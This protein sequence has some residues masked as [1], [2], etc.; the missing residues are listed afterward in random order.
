MKGIFTKKKAWIPYTRAWLLK[1]GAL[2]LVLFGLSLSQVL[3]QVVVNG[4]VTDNTTAEGLPGAAVLIK[5][6]STGT[7][8]DMDGNFRIEVPGPTTVLVVS[9]IGYVREEIVVG[10]RTT[11]NVALAPD[12][13]QLDELVVV[14]YGTQRKSD[15]TGAV[16][17]IDAAEMK[18]VAA[19]D[20]SQMLQGRT[21]GV[22]VNTD[23]HPGAMPRVRIRGI[24][25]FGDQEP[26]YVIDGVL[27]DNPP[28]DLNP[29][30]I[31]SMQVLKDASAAAIYGSRGANGVI[32][33]TTR[34]GR[35]NSPLKVEYNGYY[36]VDHVWQRI[37]VTNREQYQ[38]LQNETQRAGGQTLAPAND[39]NSPNFIDDIDTDWQREGLKT[40]NRQNHNVVLSGGGEATTYNISLDFFG[41][42]GTFIGN[43][44]SYD[45]YSARIN[46]VSEKGIFKTGISLYYAHSFE[47]SLTFR[48]DILLGGRPPLITDLVT[49]IPTMPVYDPNRLG[50][51][52]GTSST[53]ERGIVL[54]AIGANSLIENTV[55]VDR[56]IGSGWGE[57]ALLDKGGH[58]VRYKLNLA[59]DRTVAQDNAFVPAFDLGYFFTNDIARMNVGIRNWSMSLVE[60]TLHYDK[61]FNDKHALSAL[62]GATYQEGGFGVLGS[63][64]QGFSTP[65]IRNI[66]LGA[67][68]TTSQFI[69]E[70]ALASVLGRINYSFDDRYLLTASF[71]RD[72]SSRFA[73]QLR[74]GDYPSVALGW[75]L[76]NETFFALPAF[77]T[78]FK[79]RAS[80]GQLGNQTIPNY[81][82]IPTIN[83]TMPYNFG[84]VRVV[85]G[86]QAQLNAENIRWET[87]IMSNAGFDAAFFENRITLTAE[88]YRSTTEDILVGVPIPLTTGANNT[89]IVNAG[90]LRNSGVEFELGYH[91]YQGEFTFDIS[92]NAYTLKNR[93]LALG[94]DEP[95]YG[96]GARTEVGREIG[97]HFG[98]D[99]IGIFQSDEEVQAH[100][101][102]QQ[103]TAPGDV[104]FR[105]VNGDGI[106]NEQDRVYLG[107]GLP[108]I[109]Y[110]FNFAARYKGFDFTLFASGMGDYLINSR[111]YRDL[112]HTQDYL[113]YHE[114]ALG[115]WTPDNPSSTQ[116]RLVAGDPN[117]N[118][119]DSNREGWLQ[120]G[121]H[122][123][124]NTIS[125]GY[126]LPDGLIKGMSM[127]R[128]YTTAQNPYTF[129]AYKAYNPD[130]TSGTFNP[131]FDFGSFPRPRTILFGVQVAF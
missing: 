115:R 20:M 63:A 23:G 13:E 78:E 43:G 105:D 4:R 66:N 32:I 85:G 8:T 83:P 112:M 74:Y 90:S 65:Y 5:G 28:R 81:A 114:D 16:A 3:A 109:Y 95:I 60:N 67:N 97:Q 53:I 121:T 41:N 36:G 98:Y 25:T 2:S 82:Y 68:R 75:K 88:Y 51:F 11:I 94:S 9:Y 27:L 84:G 96:V 33:I 30:D 44:P 61:T 18:K 93:V 14:G 87:K 34:Q 46:T 6:T 107:S 124:I 1:A 108:G 103:G 102:Q 79:L 38:M 54:N 48:D 17:V 130:F 106:I 64:A 39:P 37:P 52:G 62:V 47:N 129:Q 29:N 110:G 56:I 125:L 49:A 123:R 127:A 73:P 21:P 118:M 12:L 126:T 77:I 24:G 100:A 104:K 31:E 57:L 10:S 113:N 55:G 101:F 99:V 131:G 119:R 45:R 76:H 42:E 117:R 19:G 89:P 40:G 80:Y 92:A 59:H 122:L 120:D 71:R 22:T 26:L 70:Y 35:K 91:K 72:G 15:I 116:P 58:S 128:V 50:G 86:S 111:L 69:E 7:V